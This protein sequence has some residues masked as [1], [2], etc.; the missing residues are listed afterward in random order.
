MSLIFFCLNIFLLQL[1]YKVQAYDNLSFISIVQTLLNKQQTYKLNVNLKNVWR[2][3]GAFFKIQKTTNSH[4]LLW[5]EF[6]HVMSPNLSK[7]C[8]FSLRFAPVLPSTMFSL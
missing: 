3:R 1:E 8:F 7:P 4:C 6:F 5:L 2:W